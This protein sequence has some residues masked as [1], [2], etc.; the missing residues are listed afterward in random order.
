M[1]ACWLLIVFKVFAGCVLLT[2]AQQQVFT[3]YTISDGLPNNSIRCIMQDSKGFMW[4]GTW[5]GLSKYDGFRFTNFTMKNG[6]PHNMINDVLETQQQSIM[7]AMNNGMTSIVENDQV[8]STPVFS[9]LT[10]NSFYKDNN[11]K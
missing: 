11:H 2:N 6:L 3:S 1:K 10:I 4:I 5:E 9:G 8:N 7:V